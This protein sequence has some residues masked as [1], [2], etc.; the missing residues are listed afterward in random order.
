MLQLHLDNT[1]IE[2]GG[3][4][5]GDLSKLSGPLTAARDEVLADAELWASGGAIPADKQ[6]QLFESIDQ[7]LPIASLG[8]EIPLEEIYLD[9]GVASA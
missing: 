4:A 9:S 8:I 5:A 1:L 3:L 6:P 7:A 2:P